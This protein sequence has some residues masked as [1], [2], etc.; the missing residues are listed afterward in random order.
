MAFYK[1]KN[2]ELYY[3]PNYVRAPTYSLDADKK[4]EYVYPIDDWY[5][6]ETNEEARSFFNIQE[7]LI[8]S[9]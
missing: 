7:V 8:N 3:A 1:Y 2:F 5:W 9:D 6:F 4:D